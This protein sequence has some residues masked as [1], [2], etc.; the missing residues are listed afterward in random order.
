SQTEAIQAI[1]RDGDNFRAAFAWKTT[2][3]PVAEM[4]LRLATALRWYYWFRSLFGL[5][6]TRLK[7]SGTVVGFRQSVLVARALSCYGFFALQQG[8]F[9]EAIDALEEALRAYDG[10]DAERD[11]ALATIHLALAE[12]FAGK[13]GAMDRLQR[14]LERSRELDDP[15]LLSYALAAA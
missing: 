3:V 13:P 9:D 2:D 6:R 10:T 11:R 7:E 15:W 12:L 1:D 14:I 8:D 5:A 4:R